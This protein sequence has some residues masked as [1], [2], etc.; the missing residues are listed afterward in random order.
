MYLPGGP[1]NHSLHLV[2]NRCEVIQVDHRLTTKAWVEPFR[3]LS[4]TGEKPDQ[5]LVTA[6]LLFGLRD[7]G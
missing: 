5:H 7:I 4:G 3:R 1:V 2:A 6:R